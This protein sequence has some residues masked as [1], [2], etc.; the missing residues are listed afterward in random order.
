M[1]E[2]QNLKKVYKSK[3]IETVAIRDIS[4]SISQ[5]EFVMILGR[6]GCGKTTLLNIL[7]GIDSI[8]EGSYRFE[9]VEI[10]RLR[11]GQIAKFRNEKVGFIFQAYHL[12]EELDAIHNVELPLGYGGW[13]RQARKK[14]AEEALQK[15]G[16]ETRMT[17]YP[18]QLSGGQQQRVA[19]ARAIVNCPKV[20]LADEPT[21]N[22]DEE[23]CHSIM[24]LLT[25]LN[26]SGTTIVMVTHDTSLIKYASRVICI[27]DGEVIREEFNRNEKEE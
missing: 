24:E 11:G 16:L 12:I 1:I 14:R 23:N 18:S 9:G 2:I 13:G 3:N 5:G 15:V 6:S 22:L 19:I 4:L 10:G 26:E 8:T 20:I 27:N 25:H 7:G 17:F 21:G